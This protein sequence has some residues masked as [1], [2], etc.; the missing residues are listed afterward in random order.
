MFSRLGLNSLL[1]VM[2]EDDT[3]ENQLSQGRDSGLGSQDSAL[4]D[5]SQ[6]DN[7]NDEYDY[8]KKSDTAEDFSEINELAEDLQSA[9]LPEKPPATGDNYDEVEKKPASKESTEKVG[10]GSAKADDDEKEKNDDS[11]PSDNDKELMPPPSTPLKLII[12]YFHQN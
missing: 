8:D 5:N 11:K 10:D 6:E 12:R 4:P 7:D 2:Q 3:A 9:M 1:E